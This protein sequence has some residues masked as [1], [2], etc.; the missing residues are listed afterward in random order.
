MAKKNQVVITYG[1]VF[2]NLS[3]M[4]PKL[5]GNF[6]KVFKFA[7]AYAKNSLKEE[8]TKVTVFEFVDERENVNRELSQYASKF[9][10]K[11]STRS[12]QV[13]VL[14][15]LALAELEIIRSR[16]KLRTEAAL[17]YLVAVD[18]LSPHMKELWLLMPRQAKGYNIQD[19]E[20]RQHAPLNRTGRFI[21]K[22]LLAVDERHNISTA[23]EIFTEHY[24]EIRQEIITSVPHKHRMVVFRNIFRV[25]KWLNVGTLKKG[26][27]GLTVEQLPPTIA[28]QIKTFEKRAP[29]GLGAF[30]SLRKMAEKHH[31][32]HLDPWKLCSIYG[33]ISA[34]LTGAAYMELEDWM[35]IE[36]LLKLEPSVGDP[37]EN[38]N[39][40]IERYRVVELAREGLG[41]KR[42]NFDSVNFGRCLY[43]IGTIGRF[44]GIFTLQEKFR[45]QYK[46]RLDSDTK[47]LR[48][49]LKKKRMSRKWI[50]DWIWKT[51]PEFDEILSKRS[52]L[53]SAPDRRLCIFFVQL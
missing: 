47:A 43:A 7:R 31:F 52:F 49:S 12:S 34:F 38:I 11:E 51:K 50:D 1:K 22:A 9:Y 15:N 5:L 17:D 13:S 4:R 28:E 18:K 37:D 24:Q 26:R 42:K 8:L 23:Q 14:K 41:Y 19:V 3:E 39:P 32:T 10:R 45:T 25:T 48:K 46:L 33:V 40:F 36:D 44:N 29:F 2:P 27:P 30:D 53:T 6:A 20:K 16:E 21:F 35:G